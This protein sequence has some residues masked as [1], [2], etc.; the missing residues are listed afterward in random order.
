[1][2]DTSRSTPLSNVYKSIFWPV[3]LIAV[4]SVW[5][6]HSLEIVSTASLNVLG[7]LWP[8][9]LIAIGLEM[10]Y[11]RQN[12]RL[13]SFAAVAVIGVAV[14]AAVFGPALFD[15]GVYEV[16]TGT[17]TEPLDDTTSATIHISTSA[18]DNTIGAGNDPVVLFFADIVYDQKGVIIFNRTGTT[19]RTV[20]IEERMTGSTS[21]SWFGPEQELGWDVELNRDVPMRLY[22]NTGVGSTNANLSD[23]QL[24]GLDVNAG[25]GNLRLTLPAMDDSYSVFINAGVGNG[26]VTIP[27]GAALSLRL[28]GG[29][30]S[31][32]V[33]I[34]D[35]AAVRIIANTGVGRIRLPDRFVQV[36]RTGNDDDGTWE[37]P[38]FANAERQIII[39]YSG[40]VGSL[41]IR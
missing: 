32:T 2:N 6:L 17:F 25:V 30:G 14:L 10:L 21:F 8:V 27:D 12:P 31:Y 29:T 26:T 19:D 4:G 1:M 28:N 34:P 35:D 40:G 18:G 37:T 41:R 22:L 15:W 5:L 33:N 16:N 38:G 20:T 7:Q 24:T 9:L 39:N 13:A 36:S 3:L 11:G 23:V